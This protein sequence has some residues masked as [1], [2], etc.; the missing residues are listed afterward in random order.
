ME[1]KIAA[2]TF[3]YFVILSPNFV[4]SFK[5]EGIIDGAVVQTKIVL[6]SHCPMDYLLTTR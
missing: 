4:F 1:S 6:S 5:R 2:F 3:C